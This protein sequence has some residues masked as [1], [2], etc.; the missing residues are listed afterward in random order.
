MNG[1]DERL[2][3]RIIPADGRKFLLAIPWIPFD[4]IVSYVNFRA[5]SRWSLNHFQSIKS[6]F[7][8]CRLLEIANAFARLLQNF[9]GR[10][11]DLQAAL[12]NASSCSMVRWKR[13]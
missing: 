7:V 6:I 13:T 9:L 4:H 11:Y 8:C 10:F 5:A 2:N 3:F 12:T 1:R